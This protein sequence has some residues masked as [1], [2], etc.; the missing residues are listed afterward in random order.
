[1]SE[2]PSGKEFN[3][4]KWRVYNLEQDKEIVKDRDKNIPRLWIAAALAVVM[5]LLS[6]ASAIRQGLI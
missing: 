6:L 4:L 1:M 2:P 3:D 5:A